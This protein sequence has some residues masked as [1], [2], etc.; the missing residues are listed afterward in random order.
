MKSMCESGAEDAFIVLLAHVFHAN[1]ALRDCIGT[2]SSSHHVLAIVG[3]HQLSQHQQLLLRWS[4]LEALL[5]GLKD[6]LW[7]RCHKFV[8]PCLDGT[9]LGVQ[10]ADVGVQ[11]LP[12]PSNLLLHLP[13][14]L[15]HMHDVV[16]HGGQAPIKGLDRTCVACNPGAKCADSVVLITV[17]CHRFA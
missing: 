12:D 14:L 17:C 16:S 9:E 13:Q 6:R 7:H 1:C 15:A 10:T 5:N 4:A 8:V 11:A 2:A 3:R